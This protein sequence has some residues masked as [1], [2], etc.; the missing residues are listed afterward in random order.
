MGDIKLPKE[1]QDQIRN[2]PMLSEVAHRL[3][4]LT[5]DPTHSIGDVLKVI[6]NDVYLTARV[7]RISNSAVYSRGT[8]IK[9]IQRAV[10]HL[11]ERFV[12]SVAVSACTGELMTKPLKGYEGPEGSLWAH[13]LKVAIAAREIAKF[14]FDN[15]S[16][17]QAYTAG[18]LM[19]IGM[20]VLSDHLLEDPAKLIKLVDENKASDFIEAERLSS[21]ADHT[22]IGF[23]VA[24]KWNLPD[25]LSAAIN[26]HHRPGEAPEQFRSLAYTVHLADLIARMSGSG[27]GIEALAHKLDSNY[28][29]Y[30]KLSKK[31]IESLI[32]VVME[33]F[34]LIEKSI[35]ST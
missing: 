12:V 26:N 20:S 22:S 1:I 10:M 5:S 14:T 11:G 8:E 15:L 9:S 6:E 17:D 29:K 31:T 32:I 18:L 30:I 33:E 35:L 19:D 13:S 28:E 16:P 25:S 4:I 21:G 23:E 3:L 7:I 24:E 34:A 2:M 27:I